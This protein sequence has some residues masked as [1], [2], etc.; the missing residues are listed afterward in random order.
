MQTSHRVTPAA[1]GPAT[2]VVSAQIIQ[3]RDYLNRSS[4]RPQ[5]AKARPLTLTCRYYAM[6]RED[7]ER[8]LRIL[9]RT[10]LVTTG[11]SYSPDGTLKL[12]DV[13]TGAV[14]LSAAEVERAFQDGFSFQASGFEAEIDADELRRL[15][16]P[17]SIGPGHFIASR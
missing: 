9:V 13:P 14:T 2:S 16:L 11:W 4:R 12:H 8:G 17:A 6:G 5:P 15:L 7:W 1:A 10:D 3:F